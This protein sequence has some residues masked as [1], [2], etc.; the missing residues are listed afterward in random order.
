M[1][2][3]KIYKKFLSMLTAGVIFATPIAANASSTKN[4]KEDTSFSLR[5]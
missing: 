1:K 4:E 3:S 5:S 2:N